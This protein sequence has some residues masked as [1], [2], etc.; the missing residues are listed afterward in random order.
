ML[1]TANIGG[2]LSLFMGFSVISIVE[3]IYFMSFRP[4]YARKRS[5]NVN[6]VQPVQTSI[7]WAMRR[8]KLASRISIIRK[9]HIE[10]QINILK[11]EEKPTYPYIE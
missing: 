7:P 6:E 2:I 3:L 11:E 8:R 5:N 4:Y 10:K 9:L 1:F